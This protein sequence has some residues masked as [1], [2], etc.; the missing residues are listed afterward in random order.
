VIHRRGIALRI[1]LLAVLVMV[2]AV[3]VIA[4]GVLVVAQSTFKNLMIQAGQSA[5]TARTMFDHS[6]VAVF[7][8]AAIVAA[9]LG[10][11]LAS[12][13]ALRL[14]R[15]LGEIAAAA[16]R[17]STGEYSARVERR[18]PEEVTSL[19]DSFNQ[20]AETLE[21]QE[22]MRR[23]FIV[24]ATHELSTPLT[25][26]QGY[27]EALRD[28]V[29]APTGEQFQ[30][31]HEEVERLVRL[32]R[33]LQTLAGNDASAPSSSAQTIDL[34]AA[35]RSA[36]ELARPS[37]EAKQISVQLNVPSRLAACAKPDQLSQV[38]ANLLQNASRYTPAGGTVAISAERRPNDALVAISNT[39]DGIPDG[40]LPRVFE[41][42]YRVEKSRDRARGGAGIGLAIV[43]QLVES[44]GGRV[45]VE[46]QAGTTRFWFSL[47]A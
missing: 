6:V 47:P 36:V 34:A 26:L 35:L 24:N 27:L 9:L 45:G 21:E 29:I 7:T 17:L 44:S 32:S 33:S 18:G 5:E 4:I 31:L 37:F 3:A 43:K 23:D 19:A 1:A 12:L 15:P 25:N 13:L 39:G 11:V 30:S 38:L 22:R 14:A 20:M 10:I 40:D 46:S 16:R 2:V 41:R 28:G 42:F 8:I